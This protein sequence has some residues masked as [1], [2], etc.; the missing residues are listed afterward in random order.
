MFIERKHLDAY[1]ELHTNIQKSKN[2]DKYEDLWF[3]V[4]ESKKK[5]KKKYDSAY[6]DSSDDEDEDRDE[7]IFNE[8]KEIKEE[9]QFKTFVCGVLPSS[10]EKYDQDDLVLIQEVFYWFFETI[11]RDYDV[12]ENDF[13]SRTLRKMLGKY[14]ED[15]DNSSEL[16]WPSSDWSDEE[17]LQPRLRL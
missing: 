11:L 17:D 13:R 10:F 5:K 16:D 2:Y 12:K 15:Y 6:G 1:W 9:K 4:C 7:R 3:Y 8:L 14:R